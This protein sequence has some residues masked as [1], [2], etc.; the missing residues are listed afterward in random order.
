MQAPN[1]SCQG[2]TVS[3]CLASL[4]QS[5]TSIGHLHLQLGLLHQAEAEAGPP[6]TGASAAALGHDLTRLAAVFLW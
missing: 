1:A 3:G 4:R 6:S 5:R 2:R